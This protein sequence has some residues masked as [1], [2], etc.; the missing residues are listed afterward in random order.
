M[1]F[2]LILVLRS[3]ATDVQIP[4]AVSPQNVEQLPDLEQFITIH[5]K[6]NVNSPTQSIQMPN[7]VFTGSNI[8]VASQTLSLFGDTTTIL[9]R[10]DG[11]GSHTR[12]VGK[13][14]IDSHPNHDPSAAIFSVR[15]SSLVLH[16]LDLSVSDMTQTIC[17]VSE[18]SI[19]VQNSAITSSTTISP[20][21]ALPF[22]SFAPISVSVI[23]TSHR[24]TSCGIVQPLVSISCPNF[25]TSSTDDELEIVAGGIS[26]SGI[27]LHLE[28]HALAHSSGP[29]FSFQT[30][31]PESG[32]K[33]GRIRTFLSHATLTNVTTTPN[34]PHFV[35]LAS[36]T[37]TVSGCDVDGCT[38]HFS[39]T[40]VH[41]I[42]FGGSTLCSNSSFANCH[43]T[44]L[45]ASPHPSEST[46]NEDVEHTDEDYEN[47][48]GQITHTSDTEDMVTVD[49]CTFCNMTATAGAAIFIVNKSVQL[50]VSASSF[51][52]CRVSGSFGDGG[53]IVVYSDYIDPYHEGISSIDKCSFSDCS[54]TDAGG[55]VCLCKNQKQVTDSYF[56]DS[57]AGVRG[58]GLLF[59]DA[60]VTLS[61]SSFLACRANSGGGLYYS[62]WKYLIYPLIL[63]ISCVSFRDCY[64]TQDVYARDFSTSASVTQT[65]TTNEMADCD[66]S[67]G[68]DNTWSIYLNKPYDRSLIPLVEKGTKIIGKSVTVA[69][70]V[71]T[72]RV[73]TEKK[74]SGTMA[75]LLSGPAV[76]RLVFIEFADSTIGSGTASVGA[77]HILPAG[78]NFEVKSVVMPGW[79]F[80]N[81]VFGGSSTRLDVNTTEL[82]LTGVGL[83]EGNYW[84]LIW[85]G[86]SLSSKVEVSLTLSGTTTLTG[87]APLYPSTA[88]GLVL[89]EMKYTV[90]EVGRELNGEKWTIVVH[91]PVEFTTPAEPARIE[92]ATCVLNGRKD[93]VIVCLVGRQLNDG[94]HLVSLR[95]SGLA[96]SVTSEIFDVHESF[97]FVKFSV[98]WEENTTHLEFGVEYEIFSV[99]NETSS[100]DTSAQ[101]LFEIPRPPL[102]SSILV[103]LSVSSSSFV[104][105]VSGSDLPSGKTYLVSLSSGPSFSLKFSSSTEGSSTLPIGGSNDLKFGTSY[106][107][108]SVILVE[109]GK[110]D[111][112][113]LLSQS[114]FTTPSGPTLSSISCDLA[115][116]DPNSVILSL[117]TLLMP[118]ETFTLRLS[119]TSTPS[120]TVDIPIEFTSAESGT[121]KVEVYNISDSLEYDCWYSIVEMWSENVVAVV[122]APVFS[123]PP[124]PVRIEGASC[125]LGGEKNKS[126][127]VV[128]SGVKLGGEKAFTLTIQKMVGST[129]SLPDLFLSG[130]LSGDALSTTH[131]HCELIFG[132]SSPLLSFE[133][134]YLVLDL[135]IESSI[136]VVNS[137][138]N[139]TVPPEPSRLTEL[140]EDVKYG[141][142]EK[143]I[144]VS[145]SGIKLEG[146]YDLTL[147]VNSTK[148]VRVNLNAVF[149]A[150]GNGVATAVLF[151]MSLPSLVDLSY[152]TRYEV[153]GVSFGSTPIQFEDGL[154]FKTIAE[155]SRLV[156][157]QASEFVD[158]L[159]T[160]I[161]LSFSTVALPIKSTVTLTLESEALDATSS[162]D[163]VLEMETDENGELKAMSAKLYPFETD[164]SEKAGQLEFG[165]NYKVKSLT[166]AS[167]GLIHF[168]KEKTRL[169]TPSEP[170]RIVGVVIVEQSDINKIELQ[171]KG[172]QI[173]EG[174]MTITLS[175]TQTNK[176]TVTFAEGRNSNES[177]SFSLLLYGVSKELE[178]GTRYEVFS[179]IS[180]VTSQPILMDGDVGFSTPTEPFR[181]VDGKATLNSQ[182]TSVIMRLSG[183]CIPDSS[184]EVVLNDG[185]TNSEV[186]IAGR[187][188]DGEIVMEGCVDG[189]V[190]GSELPRLVCGV[191]YLVTRVGKV[192]G[193]VGSELSAV[194]EEGVNVTIP[195]PPKVLSGRF[196]NVSSLWTEAEL[197]LSGEWL[198][199]R[200]VFEVCLNNTMT[201][202]VRFTDASSG[203]SEL[204]FRFGW[205]GE[206]EFGKSYSLDWI[207]KKGDPNDIIACDGVILPAIA[208]PTLLVIHSDQS[209]L[210]RSDLCGT[211]E[212][213]CHS[214]SEVFRI[215]GG[216]GFSQIEVVLD[217]V[218][219]MAE[220]IELDGGFLSFER[221]GI[222]EPTLLIPSSASSSSLSDES[223]RAGL[224]RMVGGKF[225]LRDVD[226]NISVSSSS[227]VFVS[228]VDGTM[229][230]RDSCLFISSSPSAHQSNSKESLCSWKSGVISVL[231][232]STEI[233]RTVLH[234]LWFGGIVMSGGSMTVESTTFRDNSPGDSEF[235]SCR[236]NIECWEGGSI[237][238]GSLSGGDGFKEGSSSWISAS[239]CSVTSSV[240]S[241]SSPLF[242]PSLLS[243][244]SSVSLRKKEKSFVFDLVGTELIPCGVSV[245]V[246]EFDGKTNRTGN[247]VEFSSDSLSASKWNESHVMFTL[248]QSSL[249]ELDSSMEWRS[250]FVF[251]LNESTSSVVVQLSLSDKRALNAVKSL[252]WVIP[253]IC[254]AVGLLILLFIVIVCCRRK[255]TKEMVEQK[256]MKS[257]LDY[258]MD[259]EKYEV[260]D[261]IAATSVGAVRNNTA[262]GQMMNDKSEEKTSRISDGNP[263][264]EMVCV[265]ACEGEFGTEVGP[266]RETL[267]SRLHKQSSG[268]SGMSRAEKGAILAKIVRGLRMAGQSNVTN[269]I[270]TNVS[271]HNISID[272]SDRVFLKMKEPERTHPQTGV[273][274][275]FPPPE[276]LN[277]KPE[278]CLAT[279]QDKVGIGESGAGNQ[280]LLPFDATDDRAHSSNM[281][282]ILPQND[283]F[284]RG[285]EGMNGVSGMRGLNGMTT[286]TGFGG[287]RGSELTW[288]GSS[289]LNEKSN[290][291]VRWAAPET[292]DTLA[293][294]DKEKAAV[295]SLGILLWEM[296]TEAVPFGELDG[297][298]AHR[299]LGTGTELGMSKVSSSQ[300][301]VIRQCMRLNPVE[302]PSL[303]TVA[304]LLG[305]SLLESTKDETEQTVAH[306]TN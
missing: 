228:V 97:C 29:L 303:S 167:S 82:T 3:L 50:S 63:K 96:V 263:R 88:T 93:E 85:D 99:T 84:M 278:L 294:V 70:N 60:V 304:S 153:I 231:N 138:V 149:D 137:G 300:A 156:R 132:E 61:N 188:E 196:V 190:E 94:N 281:V 98:G 39:G 44:T 161:T 245:L 68:L 107:I 62:W 215:V 272:G 66:S 108:S 4:L 276:Q 112:H 51:V 46:S 176:Q 184:F 249:A 229:M 256:E 211:K 233:T 150:E 134:S 298:N 131:S 186:V 31:S 148:S 12:P 293:V 83:R 152:N 45:L 275:D 56:E 206:L 127:I 291:D 283:S 250:H 139:F 24:T 110:D 71:A 268:S 174:K 177:T 91:S 129:P 26:V 43:S 247:S 21:V 72:I 75:I 280:S 264:A 244:S 248:S 201:I 22:P 267:Y 125:S 181:V 258:G 1:R 273:P 260:E 126:A 297:M 157:I 217:T 16:N 296:E 136:C 140:E 103:P 147:S 221:G 232:T 191:T 282:S 218:S 223:A 38:N 87:R 214:I 212:R 285:L 151:D 113:V 261:T 130:T 207:R 163:R 213:A 166:N 295:F 306:I 182:R 102:I 292:T 15:N 252:V 95:R 57:S 230:I 225:E 81:F 243:S 14:T 79:T 179:V 128:L 189:C 124:S 76:P 169:S 240:V 37:Q 199:L 202:D 242:I 101:P 6:K 257:E 74:M 170:T 216:I 106:T 53:A 284:F 30:V 279:E 100:F 271:P 251:G 164:P 192:G 238:I 269:W 236:R 222:E 289:T 173:P 226:V 172:R 36:M 42:N 23:S 111:E 58:G 197:E 288:H 41:E 18:S 145:L 204:S 219:E 194:I 105:A 116:S 89:W 20:F 2:I 48:I 154:S 114:S 146:N 220:G 159:K 143:T 301:E 65:L 171:L 40:A 8:E 121:K 235:P 28:S 117:T 290:E 253:V 118:S 104:F 175:N 262:E 77:G 180:S 142:G 274:I 185:K 246:F 47:S 73:E 80:D 265:M 69:G 286:G 239:D 86:S 49:H 115:P 183:H 254:A 187:K 67:S 27:G 165:R 9:C 209:S 144:E 198:D 92:E 119:S 158:D 270:L 224:I 123:L 13:N 162:D 11:L 5:Q 160:T 227:F 109:E 33:I 55:S 25:R 7:Q 64:A 59:E 34:R 259:D 234:S 32:A 10:P 54:A 255:K 35:N 277:E 266:R 78:T 135:A 287:E 155:P 210:N 17:F 200:G 193:E 133:T 178:Y 203:R 241:E 195:F 237:V 208:K 305:I 205:K 168:E 299:Q 122:K 19:L 90:M 120:K 52:Q 141:S 302:R